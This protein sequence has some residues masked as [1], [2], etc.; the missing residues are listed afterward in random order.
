MRPCYHPVCMHEACNCELELSRMLN[1][2][3]WRCDI[4]KHTGSHQCVHGNVSETIPPHPT[5]HLFL[6]SFK[7]REMGLRLVFADGGPIFACSSL[8]FSLSGEELCGSHYVKNWRAAFE[9][10][11]HA[12]LH[13]KWWW[14]PLLNLQF[15][16]HSLQKKTISAR[17]PQYVLNAF[18]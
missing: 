1:L 11:N 10:H 15:F 4:S 2:L 8:W 9:T 16:N 5:S 3:L 14:L 17:S 13:S 7:A 6:F 18:S 12:L